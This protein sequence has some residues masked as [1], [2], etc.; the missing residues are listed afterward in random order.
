MV[1]RDVDRL[2]GGGAVI[3]E[4]VGLDHQPEFGP[5]EIDQVPAKALL[6]ARLGKTGGDGDR[7]EAA[8]ELGLRPAERLRVEQAAR[9][10]TA[11]RRDGVEGDS[12]PVGCD[13]A[14]M[15]GLVDRVFDRFGG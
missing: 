12:Q 4:A 6:R 13:Q 14:K 5:E 3:G 7:E 11:G 1:A 2:L 8:L 10:G 9:P 15:V